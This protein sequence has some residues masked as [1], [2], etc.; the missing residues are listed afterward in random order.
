MK[1]PVPIIDKR[2]PPDEGPQLGEI[3]NT[4]IGAKATAVSWFTKI[5]V[6]IQFSVLISTFQGKSSFVNPLCP[7]KPLPHENKFPKQSIA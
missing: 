4:Q 5:Y 3:E 2:V 6:K 1:N 7:I